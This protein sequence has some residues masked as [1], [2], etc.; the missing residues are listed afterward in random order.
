MVSDGER[1]RFRP[2]KNIIDQIIEDKRSLI[3][4]YIDDHA[5]QFGEK[6][7]QRYETY[8]TQIYENP[9]F[10]KE[11]EMEI[12]GFLL[13]MKEVIAN[14]EKTRRL[15]EQV[16]GGHFELPEDDDE[17]TS[18]S[19]STT[20]STS[21]SVSTTASTSASASAST[22]SSSSSSTTT[23]ASASSSALTSASSSTTTSASSSTS[24]PASV[25][26]SASSSTS[27]SSST[28][29]SIET[30]VLQSEI[31]SI[32]ENLE[33]QPLKRPTCSCHKIPG[34]NCVH[35]IFPDT[36]HDITSPVN[37]PHLA[38]GPWTHTTTSRSI[39][40]TSLN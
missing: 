8:Q 31:K 17:T 20:A 25:S 40:K 19:V 12:G 32:V 38:F 13:D 10:R 23:S 4:R 2:K 22:T 5:D 18:A 26:K 29:T 35:D 1:F 33:Q 39:I 6:L 28:P 9:E 36:T 3:S 11:L 21:A 37:L 16:E 30:S 34:I 14:D 24:T 15:L 27:T 7:L